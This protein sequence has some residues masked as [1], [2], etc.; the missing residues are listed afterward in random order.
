LSSS[1]YA[2]SYSGTLQVVAIGVTTTTLPGA[3]VQKPYSATLTAAGGTTAYAWSIASGNLPTGLKLST[4]GTVS[5]TPTVPGSFAFTVRVTDASTPKNTA[6]KAFTIV[7]APMTIATTSLPDGKVKSKY[8]QA[9]AVN[10]GKPAYTFTIASGALPPGLK[11]ATGGTINGTPTTAGRY[12]FTVH[13][14]DKGVPVNS[15]NQALVI[16]ITP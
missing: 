6:T 16:T 3:L 11:L 7:V 1:N 10:G 8:S 13:V 9:L 4:N 15:A 2:A 14:T 5:G 12:A